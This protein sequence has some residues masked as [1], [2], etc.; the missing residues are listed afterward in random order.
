MDTADKLKWAIYGALVASGKTT[1]EAHDLVEQASAY[2]ESLAKLIDGGKISFSEAFNS[3]LEQFKSPELTGKTE[4]E[5][6]I[7]KLIPI[8]KEAVEKAVEEALSREIRA[9]GEKRVEEELVDYFLEHPVALENSLSS[10]PGTV[11][12]DAAWTAFQQVC[13]WFKI[14]RDIIFNGSRDGKCPRCGATLIMYKGL[15][16]CPKCDIVYSL[17]GKHLIPEFFYSGFKEVYEKYKD[18]CD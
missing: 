16:L 10:T 15:Y 14:R 1:V 11:T 4:E 9:E 18:Y 3:C 8:I 12:H 6:T 13:K 2:I 7:E 5:K 17:S